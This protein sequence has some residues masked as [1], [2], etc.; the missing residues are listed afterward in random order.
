MVM[1]SLQ[2]F[3]RKQNLTVFLELLLRSK[4]SYKLSKIK[5]HKLCFAKLASVRVMNSLQLFL[6]KQ[7][8]IIL[9]RVALKEQ[10]KLQTFQNQEAQVTLR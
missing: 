1:N 9:F 8:L 7:N 10:G 4:E 2:L 3:L 5:R 6:R